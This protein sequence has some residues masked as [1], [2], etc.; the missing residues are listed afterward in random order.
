MSGSQAALAI[1]PVTRGELERVAELVVSTYVDGEFID[2]DSPYLR[3]LRDVRAR[4]REA[5]LLVARVHGRVVGT[6]TFCWPGT[7]WA[8]ISRPGEAEFRMLAVARPSQG[9]GIGRSLVQ[10]C[11]RRSA[12][13]GARATVISSVPAM[14]VA[15]RMY[16]QMGFVR[17]PERD[18]APRPGVDL[19]TYRRHVQA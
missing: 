14:R 2:A 8:E 15:G 17:T 19:V 5:D 7:R 13:G 9:Q 4:S 10:E 6:V 12:A 3:E 16:R 18:W 1:G 11:L